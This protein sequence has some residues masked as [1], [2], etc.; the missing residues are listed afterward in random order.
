M[1]VSHGSVTSALS[2]YY[3]CVPQCRRPLPPFWPSRRLSGA[4]ALSNLS[5]NKLGSILRCINCPMRWEDH[6]IRPTVLR[7]AT[8]TLVLVLTVL[9]IMGG[10]NRRVVQHEEH[11]LGDRTSV[12]KRVQNEDSPI[13]AR[14]VSPSSDND[15]SIASVATASS[16]TDLDTVHN[17]PQWRAYVE[18]IEGRI[19]ASWHRPAT[20]IRPMETVCQ[21]DLVQDRSGNIMEVSLTRCGTDIVLQNS[22]LAA[23]RSAAPFP[24]PANPNIFRGHAQLSVP[25]TP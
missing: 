6:V 10:K 23:V 24:P 9:A 7:I 25:L 16:T 17:D 5:G 1:V 14:T 13:T 21:F 20:A 12:K 3:A 19:I 8:A 22:I 15:V 11:V 18:A 2:K 4:K